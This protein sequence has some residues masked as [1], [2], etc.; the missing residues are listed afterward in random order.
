M[1]RVKHVEENDIGIPRVKNNGRVSTPT[2]GGAI[3]MKNAV[4]LDTAP[5]IPNIS[6]MPV[7][8]KENKQSAHMPVKEEVKQDIKAAEQPVD[9]TVDSLGQLLINSGCLLAK[10]TLGKNMDFIGNPP[11]AQHIACINTLLDIYKALKEDK[12]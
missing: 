3:E 7:K 12:P 8:K 2:K 1:P 9:Y 6:K 5:I 11:S 10:K 4:P